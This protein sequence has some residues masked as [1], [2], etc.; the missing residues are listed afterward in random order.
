M[1]ASKHLFALFTMPERKQLPGWML[2]L[3]CQPLQE[4]DLLEPPMHTL[5]AKSQQA[6][7]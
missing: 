2:S 4:L 6:L 5:L 3:L 1:I 7:S